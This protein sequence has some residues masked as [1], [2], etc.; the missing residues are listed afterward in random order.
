MYHVS[1]SLNRASIAARGLDW[2]HMGAA[3]GI[4]GDD[5]PDQEGTF[6]CRDEAE[7]RFF[8]TINN[9]GGPVDVWVVDGVAEADLIVAPEGFAYVPV[10]IPPDCLTFLRSE[11]AHIWP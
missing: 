4:A 8:V 11:V 9:T 1:S 7:V 10:A 2:R 3:R 6:L 5:R